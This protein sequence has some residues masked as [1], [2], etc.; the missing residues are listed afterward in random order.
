MKGQR[1]KELFMKKNYN[2]RVDDNGTAFLVV[3]NMGTEQR[4]V[5]GAFSTLRIYIPID[6]ETVYIFCVMQEEKSTADMIWE[7]FANIICMIIKK[8]VKISHTM[9]LMSGN[10]K[11]KAERSK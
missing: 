11:S 4:L 2:V 5:V 8:I 6:T 7:V 3:I 10:C 9:Q 1:P